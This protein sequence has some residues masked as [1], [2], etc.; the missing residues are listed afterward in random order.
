MCQD[1]EL[2]VERR[3]EYS[4]GEALN[5]ND[6]NQRLH[7]DFSVGVDHTIHHRSLHAP[8]AE[9]QTP[10]V[11]RVVIATVFESATNPEIQTVFGRCVVGTSRVPHVVGMW[12]RPEE[13]PM[14]I[15]HVTQFRCS[16]HLSRVMSWISQGTV[17]AQTVSNTLKTLLPLVVIFIVAQNASA[18]SRTLTWVVPHYPS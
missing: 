7:G 17:A 16:G 13:S 15:F 14:T 12:T 4:I 11:Q 5:L 10:S 9:T 8:I 18:W 6:R 3:D 1:T 2:D